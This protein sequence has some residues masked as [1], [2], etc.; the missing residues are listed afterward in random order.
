MS[1]QP[2]NTMEERS[3]GWTKEIFEL[4]KSYSGFIL[5][6]LIPSVYM[7]QVIPALDKL[8]KTSERLTSLQASFDSITPQI[9]TIG[10]IKTSVAKIATA[11][12]FLKTVP[13]DVQRLNSES[14][15]RYVRTINEVQILEKSVTDATKDLSEQKLQLENWVLKLQAQW[16]AVEQQTEKLLAGNSALGAATNSIQADTKQLNETIDRL[17]KVERSVALISSYFAS[18]GLAMRS[19]DL[20]RLLEQ[21]YGTNLPAV[22]QLELDVGDLDMKTDGLIHVTGVASYAFEVKNFRDKD[23]PVETGI[24]S[25]KVSFE[26]HR[27]LVEINTKSEESFS[28]LLQLG[29][30]LELMLRTSK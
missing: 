20:A 10:D 5:L 12:E 2:T 13:S 18:N 23:I 11:Q 9:P 1:E 17:S 25:S 4:A 16:Q 29:L 8:D 19:L 6:V 21:K 14:Q 22:I 26:G 3:I 7:L 24:R 30:S 28:Q 27:V 15:D